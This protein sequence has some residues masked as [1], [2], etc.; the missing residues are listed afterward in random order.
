MN[1]H[2]FVLAACLNIL[3]YFEHFDWEKIDFHYA[4]LFPPK[5]TTA[6]ALVYFWL[7]ISLTIFFSPDT[8]S[9]K[10]HQKICECGKNS[11]REKKW[12]TADCH[13]AAVFWFDDS[14][15]TE[16]R[17]KFSR[18]KHKTKLTQHRHQHHCLSNVCLLRRFCAVLCSVLHA[19]CDCVRF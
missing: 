2:R 15:K 10:V 19:V 18:G 7:E 11:E 12:K 16:K 17:W 6:I 13:G 1:E 4:F 9:F 3:F 14:H 5:N 8:M